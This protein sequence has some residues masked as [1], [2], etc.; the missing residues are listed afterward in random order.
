[1]YIILRT[2]QYNSE[3]DIIII[4]LYFN[5]LELCTYHTCM[6]DAQDAEI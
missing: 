6:Q 3:R 2:T 4:A 1:M 5:F